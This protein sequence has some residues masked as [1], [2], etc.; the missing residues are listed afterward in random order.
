MKSMH[1]FLALGSL[2]VLSVS[3]NYI[4]FS[5]WRCPLTNDGKVVHLPHESDCSKFY[6]CDWSEAI[7][8]DC[9]EGLLF[10][11]ILSVCDWPDNVDCDDVPVFQT[12]PKQV[13]T[14]RPV[15]ETTPGDLNSNCPG[16]NSGRVVHLPHESQCTQFYKC[17][18]GR[19]VLQYCPDGLH[20]NRVLSVC[21]WPVNAKCA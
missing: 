9:P 21:D 16:D 6:K 13:T 8:Q 15:S 10:N 20:F 4:G 18:W 12:T 17:D 19:A 11:A 3:A 2:L 1:I 7:L 14:D 5:E